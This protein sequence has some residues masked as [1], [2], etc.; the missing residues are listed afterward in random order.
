[1]C[2]KQWFFILRFKQPIFLPYEIRSLLPFLLSGLMFCFHGT[3]SL[4]NSLFL[5]VATL[6][7]ATFAINAAATCQQNKH[8]KN[9][10]DNDQYVTYKVIESLLQFCYR[11]IDLIFS[12]TDK[13]NHAMRSKHENREC[14]VHKL[15]NQSQRVRQTI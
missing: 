10:N 13:T 8:T 2:L 3:S 6:N 11:I 4:F 15:W 7:S 9:R 1:M 12:D 5:F 14:T